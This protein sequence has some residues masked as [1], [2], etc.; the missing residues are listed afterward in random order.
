MGYLAPQETLDPKA[1]EDRKEKE[2]NQELGFQGVQ[3]FQALQKLQQELQGS[4]GQPW[5]R[6]CNQLSGQS[7]APFRGT[8]GAAETRSLDK[9]QKV[10]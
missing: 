7:Y 9:K 4:T 3:G 10:Q 5:G 6:M 1:I 2:E 8:T